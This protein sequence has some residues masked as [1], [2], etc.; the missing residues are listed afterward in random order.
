MDLEQEEM[1]RLRLR[2]LSFDPTSN[3]LPPTSA[4]TSLPAF[5]TAVPIKFSKGI[6]T[7]GG[8]DGSP[9]RLTRLQLT[10]LASDLYPPPSARLPTLP[11]EELYDIGIA[12]R[13]SSPV[14]ML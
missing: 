5:Y 12:S 9:A 8:D 4:S 3:L 14:E 10:F 13:Q 7:P 6:L 1:L 2:L 11:T